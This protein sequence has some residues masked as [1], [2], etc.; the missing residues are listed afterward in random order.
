MKHLKTFEN[1]NDPEV[2]DYVIAHCTYTNSS[3]KVNNFM[4]NNV[5]RIVNIDNGKYIIVYE[6][7]IPFKH[8][9]YA[10]RITLTRDNIDYFGKN[11]EN[12]EIMI[13]SNKYNL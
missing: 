12:L 4:L 10:R 8:T 5:G 11:E 13:Q 1:I 3:N 9:K 6:K 7:E 2:G